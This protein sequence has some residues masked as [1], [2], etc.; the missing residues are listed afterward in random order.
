[1]VAYKDWCRGQPGKRK[2]SMAALATVKKRLSV[3][4][5]LLSYAERN[6]LAEGND[7]HSCRGHAAP[8]AAAL[9]ALDTEQG[10]NGKLKHRYRL[11]GRGAAADR[12]MK[13]LSLYEL[14][15]RPAEDAVGQKLHAI[16]ANGSRLEL[17]R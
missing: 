12:L 3:I 10:Q 11:T 15:N 16:H 7:A 2:G 14:G 1:M 9:Q 17:K 13:H 5:M 6:D 4:K 8:T